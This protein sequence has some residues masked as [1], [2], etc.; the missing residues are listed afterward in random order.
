MKNSTRKCKKEYCEKVFL[1]NSQSFSDK[2]F[3]KLKMKPIKFTEKQKK[4]ML[5]QC[6]NH[7]CNPTCK[8]TIFQDGKEF[9]KN[10]KIK[11]NKKIKELLGKIIRETRKKMFGNKT[12]VLK[13]GF[14]EKLT[15]KTVKKLKEK[16][17]LSG[18]TNGVFK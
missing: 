11:G 9:P 16:G 8:K 13:N 4:E 10:I 14:Y 15:S 7:Y 3:K 12:T 1:K 18:C 6:P 5:K 17:A 2:L